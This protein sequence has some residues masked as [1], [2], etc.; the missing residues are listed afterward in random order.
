MENPSEPFVFSAQQAPVSKMNVD[1]SIGNNDC[2]SAKR[3]RADDDVLGRNDIGTNQ[4]KET[5]G[6]FKSKL[7]ENMKKKEECPYGPWLLVSYGKPNEKKF[8]G[9][10]GKMNTGSSNN[11]KRSEL[12][13]KYGANKPEASG[14]LS[15]PTDDKLGKQKVAKNS[16][17]KEKISVKGKSVNP[18][19]GSCSRFD[20]LNKDVEDMLAGEERQVSNKVSI[21]PDI[22]E[23]N[24]LVEITNQGKDVI[25]NSSLRGK[26]HQKSG[27]SPANVG[28][29]VNVSVPCQIQ[30]ELNIVPNVSSSSVEN[31]KCGNKP[32]IQHDNSFEVVASELVEAMALVSE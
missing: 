22:D 4:G 27:N 21:G 15:I 8:R 6:S 17:V 14:N 12:S 30:H 23:K 1:A 5:G 24:A 10:Y 3:A 9:R 29:L 28:E 26:N 16:S 25:S 32:V 19:N 13:G 7:M 31:V 20:I 11:Y 2:S 18:G